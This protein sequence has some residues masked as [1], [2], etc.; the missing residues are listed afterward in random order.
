M[1]F[2]IVHEFDIPLDAVEL[3]VLSPNLIDRLAPKLPNVEKVHQ[4][5]HL[6]KNGKFERVWSYHANVKVPSFAKN[7]L[8]PEM[9]GWDEHSIYDLRT[10]KARWKIVPN[11]KP[12]WRKYF[13]S[14]GTYEL[15][16]MSRGAEGTRR[17]I[18]GELDLNVPVVRQ[19]AE[20]MILAEVKKTFDA[21]AATLRDMATLV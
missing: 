9:L 16:P 12:A 13:H 18:V 17:I 2:E 11:V 7:Y 4:K 20:R 14:A 21:E 19:V 3:A 5:E 8:T 15:V 1:H 6:M 10:H